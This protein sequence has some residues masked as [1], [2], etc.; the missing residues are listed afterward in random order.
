MKAPASE[1]RSDSLVFPAYS[2]NVLCVRVSELWVGIY[3][4]IEECVGHWFDWG[5]GTPQREG[6]GERNSGSW[7]VSV[8][9]KQRPY[10]TRLV[11][12]AHTHMRTH[13]RR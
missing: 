5:R 6:G 13:T 9:S 3:S 10:S 8:S 1:G 4:I 2:T 11:S 7:F 12:H